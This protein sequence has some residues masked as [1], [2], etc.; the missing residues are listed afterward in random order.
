MDTSRRDLLRRQSDLTWALFEYHLERLEPED[1]F[2]EPAP[3]QCWTVR[4]DAGGKWV[5]DWADTEPDPVPV[6]TIAWLSWHIGWWWGTASDHARGRTPRGRG[7]VVWPGGGKAAVEWLR[8][9]R[10]HWLEVLEGITEAGMDAAAP[11]PWPDGAGYTVA[12]MAAWVNSELMKNAA[13]IGQLRTLRAASP[14]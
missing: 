10:T 6:P 12:D 1:F 13:E 4:P 5:P 3:G 7:D 2:W 8:G 14:G 9:L 11:F